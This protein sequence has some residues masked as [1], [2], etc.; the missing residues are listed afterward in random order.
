MTASWIKDLTDDELLR[1]V[2]VERSAVYELLRDG[3][4]WPVRFADWCELL[5]EVERRGLQPV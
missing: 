3:E 1:Q 2:S 5:D 4:A